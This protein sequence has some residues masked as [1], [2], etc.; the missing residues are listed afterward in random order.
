MK[1]NIIKS[2]LIVGTILVS[3]ISIS[4]KKNETSAA[5]AYKNTYSSAI[6]N[7]NLSGA[8][9]AL[10]DAKRYIDEAAVNIETK[11][12]P[13]TQMLKG[14]IYST[15]YLLGTDLKDTSLLN[16]VGTSAMHI[17]ATAFK[18]GY[19]INDKFKSDIKDVVIE[20]HTAI[21]SLSMALY[22]NNNFKEAAEMYTIQVELYD[23]IN[24]L[25]TNSLFNSALCY[26]KSGD[27]ANAA[28]SFEKLAKSGYKGALT[29]ALA[30]NSY[31]KNKQIAEAKAIVAEGRI[32][33]P[34][35]KD[36]LLE[37]VNT[38]LEGNDP[39]GAESLLTEAI[40]KDPKNKLLHLT[41]GS[42]YIDLKQN[43]KAEESINNALAIDPDYEDALYQLGAHLVTWAGSLIAQTNNLKYNDPKLKTLE[44]QAM[45]IYNRAITPLEKYIVKSPNDKNV[46]TILSQLNRSIGN[47]EKSDQYKERAKAIK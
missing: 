11:E 27:N 13:K 26:D 31:R 15:I 30:S 44:K 20:K 29:Y 21:E 16:S 46:L 25:D 8:K 40:S 37:A 33:Y 9:K 28:L 12:S 45:E 14:S 24:L 4:Q 1:N 17:A 10:T 42:I 39:Q 7:N 22:N 47:M 23:A 3:N 2:T 43:E 35:D 41:I 32:K 34:Q 5:V 6:S 36:I 18:T 19:N 38:C